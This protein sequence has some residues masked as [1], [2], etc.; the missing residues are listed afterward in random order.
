M[1]PWSH[2][3][4]RRRRSPDPLKEIDYDIRENIINYEDKGSG[5]G[6]QA[7]FSGGARFT[8]SANMAAARDKY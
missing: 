5:K 7:S 4:S 6:D 2:P 3:H 8:G 1:Q